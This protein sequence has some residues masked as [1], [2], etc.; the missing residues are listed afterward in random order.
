MY[1]ACCITS[2][3]GDRS[4]LIDPPFVHS[5]I[6]Y[7]A[8]VDKLHNNIRVWKQKLIHEFS[9]IDKWT[10]RRNAKIYK[11]LPQI[12]L[13]NYDYYIW[14]DSNVCFKQSPIDI[15]NKNNTDAIFFSH[16]RY[17]TVSRE[18]EKVISRKKDDIHVVKL[19]EQ[20]LKEKQYNDDCLFELPL[21][22]T[23][24]VKEILTFRLLWWELIC[25]FSSRDQLTCPY[26]LKT[27][28][29]NYFTINENLRYI[30]SMDSDRVSIKFKPNDK[31]LSHKR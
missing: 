22:A 29:A 17:N 25:K 20:F 7:F 10:N 27:S 15:L 5:N 13:P 28:K 14:V 24:A 9:N 12:F 11:I 18:I 4:K 23:T 2:I 26:A 1:K 3:T 19:F 21:F 30:T 31:S 6:D 8:F 16:Y